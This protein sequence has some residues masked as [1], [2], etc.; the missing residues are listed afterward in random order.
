MSLSHILSVQLVSPIVSKNFRSFFTNNTPQF[1]LNFYGVPCLLADG[2]AH[3]V[4]H[5]SSNIFSSLASFLDPNFKSSEALAPEVPLGLIQRGRYLRSI[6][7]C[8]ADKISFSLPPSDWLQ[9]LLF[10]F[11]PFADVIS[12]SISALMK[13][14][15][16][17]M[18]SFAQFWRVLVFGVIFN[19]A[20]IEFRFRPAYQKL[21][22]NVLIN[23]LR[24]KSPFLTI[25]LESL[26]DKSLEFS[27]SDWVS[28]LCDLSVNTCSVMGVTVPKG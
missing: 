17:S 12:P 27:V 28:S 13:L 11:Q 3:S 10:H 6:H 5:R 15:P 9:L 26:P 19:E 8:F 20:T 16:M 22:V 24:T 21:S 18:I 7:G 23:L 2:A 4:L 1:Y 25:L 14:L